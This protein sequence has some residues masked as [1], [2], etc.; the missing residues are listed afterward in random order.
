VE[1]SQHIAYASNLC[2]SLRRLFGLTKDAGTL[3]ESIAAGREAVGCVQQPWPDHPDVIRAQV[4]LSYALQDAYQVHHDKALI[5]EAASLARA[6]TRAD[7]ASAIMRLRS[8]ACLVGAL[9]LQG[10]PWAAVR[11]EYAT[12]LAG[13]ADAL[14]GPLSF[15]SRRAL[16]PELGTLAQDAAGAA[17]AVGDIPAAATLFE[18]GRALLWK[19]QSTAG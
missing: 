17:I 14:D 18:A 4:N 1:H 11:H 10:A 7:A 9:T 2:A 8:S 12:A 13:L 3:R 5:E 6:A 15:G 16:V 19:T